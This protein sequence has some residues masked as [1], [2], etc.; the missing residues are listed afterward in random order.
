[1]PCSVGVN[2]ARITGWP[3][4]SDSSDTVTFTELSVT[5][6][7]FARSV[8]TT[9]AEYLRPRSQPHSKL[10]TRTVRRIMFLSSI[11]FLTQPIHCSNPSVNFCPQCT[12]LIL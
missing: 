5:S 6:A 11:L 3:A 9:E 7:N 2:V 4:E 1:K 12:R 10:A 8:N